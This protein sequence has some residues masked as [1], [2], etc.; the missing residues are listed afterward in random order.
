MMKKKNNLAEDE[1]RVKVDGFSMKNTD[2]KKIENGYK[3]VNEPIYRA[4]SAD[5]HEIKNNK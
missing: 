2:E 4:H 1:F 3:L 5:Y